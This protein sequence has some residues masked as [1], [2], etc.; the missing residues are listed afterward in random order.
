MQFADLGFAAE[1]T[2]TEGWNSETRTE[3]ESY[4]THDP[5]GCFIAEADGKRVG[6]GVATPYEGTGSDTCGFIGEI[7]VTAE[8]RGQGIGRQLLEH[9]IAHLRSRG[10]QSIYLDGVIKALP[11]YERAGFYKICR[12]LRFSG[13]LTGKP[14]SRVRGLRE[15]HLPAVLELD[16]AA[17]GA[18]R[19][20]FIK[21]RLSLYPELCKVLVEDGKITGFILARRGQGIVS[22]GPWVIQQGV[23]R[24]GEM[25]EAL[26]TEVNIR[27]GAGEQRL[28]IGVLETNHEAIDTLAALGFTQRSDPPWRMVLGIAG[29]LGESGQCLATGSAAKG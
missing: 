22:V 14:G 25:L 21:R 17:F 8:M 3:F 19:G 18:D 1:C 7:I 16:R 10:A 6:I 23:E 20:F 24:A 26:A 11:L 28:S 4:F 5:Q 15:N 29:G 12:S 2:A 9:G 13:L 27:R